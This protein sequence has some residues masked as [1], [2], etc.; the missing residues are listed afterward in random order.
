[1][2]FK[3]YIETFKYEI[4]QMSVKMK[5]VVWILVIA[6]S[7]FIAGCSGG[8]D[9]G[10]SSSSTPFIG[11]SQGIEINFLEGAPPSEILDDKQVD[12]DIVLNVENV[13]EQDIALKGLITTIAGIFPGDF[14]DVRL[15]KD[16]DDEVGSFQG[17]KKDLDGD[18]IPGG[19]G[20]IEFKGLEYQDKLQGNAE[21]PIQADVCYKYTTKAVGDF[22]MRNDVLKAASSGVCNVKGSKPIFSSGAPIHVVSLDESAAGRNKVILKFNIKTV[23]GGA[24]YKPDTKSDGGPKCQRGDFGTENRIKVKIDTGVVGLKCSGFRTSDDKKSA[25][26]DNVRLSDGSALVT[27]TQSG[28]DVDAVKKVNVFL[29]Y[30]HLVSTSTKFVVQHVPGFDETTTTTQTTTQGT[31]T[32]TDDADI[33]PPPTAPVIQGG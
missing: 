26:D 3:P 27:C 29:E 13:G 22:C 30:N 18:K 20:Q 5:K 25:T 28:V 16:N 10:T 4:F 32:T 1:M 15:S 11:G 23:G 33:P 21:F 31:T 9:D 17:V 14:G 6:L 7:V 2:F 19:I 24:F 12:F 8:G